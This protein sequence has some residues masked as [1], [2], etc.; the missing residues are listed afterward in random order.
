MKNT[1]LNTLKGKFSLLLVLCTLSLSL[2][3]QQ[4]KELGSYLAELNATGK[5]VQMAL[6]VQLDSLTSD[7]KPTVNIG[8]TISAN[9]VE[10]PVRALVKARAVSKLSLNEP[11]Y[12]G[13]E[14]ITLRIRSAAD[15]NFLLNLNTLPGFPVLRFVLFQCEFECNPEDLE[16]LYLPNPAITVLYRISIAS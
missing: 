11:L 16:S 14:L 12:A 3:A 15:M 8:S 9:S 6:A 10:T 4:I 2:P 13:V 5:D 7:I 1:I